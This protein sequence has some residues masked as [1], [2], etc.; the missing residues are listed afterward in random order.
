S[1]LE[2]SLKSFLLEDHGDRVDNS[3]LLVC[4]AV[5]DDFVLELFRPCDIE[6]MLLSKTVVPTTVPGGQPVGVALPSVR[7]SGAGQR[8]HIDVAL[9]IRVCGEVRLGPR[10]RNH[11]QEHCCRK[12]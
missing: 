6:E 7:K 2:P 1:L 9:G 3:N 10:E 8:L 12:K 5:H 4:L 11:C